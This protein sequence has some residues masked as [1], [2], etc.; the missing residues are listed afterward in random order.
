MSLLERIEKLSR[1]L[2]DK[3]SELVREI[4]EEMESVRKR[5]LRDIEE[6]MENLRRLRKEAEELEE[7]LRQY[8]TYLI[9]SVEYFSYV[10]EGNEKPRVEYKRLYFWRE[11]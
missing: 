9:G 3:L 2:A 4:E 1:T 11:E 6:A 8:K 5:A 7:V 10:R